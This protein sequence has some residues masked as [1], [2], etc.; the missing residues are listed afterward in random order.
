[1]ME[2]PQRRQNRIPEYDYSGANAYFITI[3]T[4]DRRNLFWNVGAVIDRPLAETDYSEVGKIVDR[5]ISE[6]P[7]HYPAV[8]LEKYV[9]MPNHIHIL[10]R[11][12]ADESGRPMVAPTVSTVVQQMKGSA[13]K[14]AGFPLWQK[15]FYDHVIRGYEDYLEIWQYIDS[16]PARWSEDKLFPG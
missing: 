15:G 12:N 8:S 9:I 5:V 1:M 2:Y 14:R 6:I 10:L 7:G 4:K 16:N 11:I 13:S 3:C